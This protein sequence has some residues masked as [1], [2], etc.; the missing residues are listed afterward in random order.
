MWQD[1]PPIQET[2]T[3]LTEHLRIERS[4]RRRTRLQVL[5]LLQSGQAQTRQEVAKLVAVQRHTIGRWL[6]VYARAGLKAMLM[7]QTHSNRAPALPAPV[8]QALA[9]QLQDPHGF[10]SYG[11]V[12][13]WV[14]QQHGVRVKY[15]TLHRL[16]RYQLKAKLKVP[17]ASHVKKTSPRPRPSAPVSVSTSTKP[18]VRTR[19]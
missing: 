10:G 15:K 7:L 13:Q 16:I 19:P 8:R 1:I 18:S 17:R 14:W 9:R 2:L 5:Y 4:V 12:Q 3:E 11:E 6:M